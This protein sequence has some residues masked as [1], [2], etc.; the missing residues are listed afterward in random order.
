MNQRNVVLSM[1]VSLDGYTEGPNRDITWH[2]WD[3]EMADYMMGLFQTVDTFLYGRVSYELMLQ[4]WPSQTGEFA[5]VMNKTPKIVFSRTLDDVKWN[6]RLVKEN[7]PEE[8][9][10][11]KQQPG[12]DLVLFAGADLASTFIRNGLI[13]KYRLI[14]NPVVLGEGTPLFK[15]VQDQLNLRLTRSQS[16]RCGNVLLCYE[17]TATG[18]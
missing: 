11:L 13:D 7:V 9:R 17:P 16:F 1:M 6:S 5:D 8:I 4:Y 3:D 10:K 2:V 14:V 18:H 15:D 12:K